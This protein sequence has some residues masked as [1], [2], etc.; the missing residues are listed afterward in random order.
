VTACRRLEVDLVGELH[1]VGLGLYD[2]T[3]MSL[4]GLEA[5][6]AADQVFAE[7]YTSKL[8]GATIEVLEGRIGKPIKVLD[9][10]SVESQ[11]ETVLDVAEQ[12]K[13]VMLVVGDPM[14]ATTHIDLRL[15][16]EGRGVHT[17]IFHGASILT[18]A[19]TELGLSV[20][21][22]G[23]VCTLQWPTGT[24]FPSSPYEQLAENH[25]SD[26]HTLVLMDI[27]SDEGRYMTAAEGCQLLL[28][29]ED[30]LGYGVTGPDALACVVARAGAPDCL[31][32]A[33]RLEDLAKMEFGPAL[34]S[35]VVVSRLHFMEARALVVL[36]GADPKLVEKDL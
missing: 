8:T 11:P 29:Y 6:Q 10:E 15:Q 35:I 19:F 18:A 4:A 16:A 12:G 33:G 36:A 1:F 32:V 28:R 7:F 27:R 26:L 17:R 21:K 24:Y 31:R 13:A 2:E 23:R 9:R 22:S 34:H 14:A 5:A 25:Q 20:Y 30:E 3:D